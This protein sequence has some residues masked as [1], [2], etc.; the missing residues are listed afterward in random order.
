ML[1][2]VIP[3]NSLNFK[4]I[5]YK[6]FC[7]NSTSSLKLLIYTMF[8]VFLSIWIS[9][10]CFSDCDCFSNNS[11]RQ[12]WEAVFLGTRLLVG[13]RGEPTERLRSRNSVS[14]WCWRSTI[15]R[16]FLRVAFSRQSLWCICY[17]PEVRSNCDDTSTRPRST[18]GVQTD[19]CCSR[20]WGQLGPQFYSHC[21]NPRYGPQWQQTCVQGAIQWE[22]YDYCLFTECWGSA[23]WSSCCSGLLDNSILR[24]WQ[25]QTI[26]INII[27][28]KC[29][30]SQP[31]ISSIDVQFSP[32]C[33]MLWPN[34]S[35][36][37]S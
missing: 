28:S 25:W 10:L 31:C 27:W 29:N 35:L 32:M 16:V 3:V 12:W 19:G 13:F 6:I 17:W 9:M 20:W 30:N 15:Q 4:A 7:I 22:Q 18:V 23:P 21:N 2:N 14:T 24:T 8:I 33:C 26:S 1:P 36:T 5:N 37:Y 34:C 11:W